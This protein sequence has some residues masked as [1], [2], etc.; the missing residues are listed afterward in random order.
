MREFILITAARKVKNHVFT[1]PKSECVQFY[2][3]NILPPP[4]IRLKCDKWNA[5][6]TG[7]SRKAVDGMDSHPAANG[8]A[9]RQEILYYTLES[10]I[11]MKCASEREREREAL[12]FCSFALSQRGGRRV[13]SRGACLECQNHI[14]G[15]VEWRRFTQQSQFRSDTKWWMD[16]V[17]WHIPSPC[18]VVIIKRLLYKIFIHFIL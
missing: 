11:K 16:V 4:Q 13:K 8:I 1:E 9:I 6:E 17:R 3:N 2:Q 15:C 18:P 5:D 10:G 7:R 14:T 12:A